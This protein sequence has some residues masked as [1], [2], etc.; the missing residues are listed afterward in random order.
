MACLRMEGLTAREKVVLAVIAF[1]D[2]SGSAWPSYQRIADEAKCSRSVV[3]EA[4]RE[5]RAQGAAP[6]HA[7]AYDEQI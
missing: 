4:I 3:G 2:G 5:L 7:V 1:H 6:R